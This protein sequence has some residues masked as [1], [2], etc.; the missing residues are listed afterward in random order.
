MCSKPGA[1][2]T[3]AAFSTTTVV[4]FSVD[5]ILRKHPGLCVAIFLQRY[6]SKW[7]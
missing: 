4:F 7:L 5:K 1:N 6:K 3:T 2:P